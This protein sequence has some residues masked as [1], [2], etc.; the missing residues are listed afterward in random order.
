MSST[1]LYEKIVVDRKGQSLQGYTFETPSSEV[2][3]EHYIYKSNEA[4]TS[5]NM[6]LMR[7]PGLQRYLRGTLHD[8][9]VKKLT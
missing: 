2:Y 6:Y 7:S 8:W 3:A 1:P 9:G 5:Y 4:T